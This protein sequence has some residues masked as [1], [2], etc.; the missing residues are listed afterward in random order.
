M[1]HRRDVRRRPLVAA[2]LTS[3]GPGVVPLLSQPAGALAPAGGTVF[4]NEIHY[5]NVGTDAGE[6]IEIAGP[7]GPDLSGWS[8]V[9]YNGSGGAAYGTSALSGTIPDQQGAF[10]TVAVAYPSNGIQNGS[11]D[12]IALVDGAGQVVQVLSY[13]GIFTAVGGPADGL[14]TSDIGVVETSTTALGASL[15]LTGA[16]SGADAPRE[17]RSVPD[18]TRADPR[19]PGLLPGASAPLASVGD[20]RP[21]RSL[22]RPGRVHP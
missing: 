12:G 6:A 21:R 14:T 4:V 15:Q 8:I 7:A 1:Q 17:A 13:E 5:D 9:L 18:A 2:L 3:L 20:G 19:S 22:A 10:G 11:P 16:A